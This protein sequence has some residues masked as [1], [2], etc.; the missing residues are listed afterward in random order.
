MK[1]IEFLEI[2]QCPSLFIVIVL[3]RYTW[4]VGRR[5]F[6]LYS[7]VLSNSGFVFHLFLFDCLFLLIDQNS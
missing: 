2:T 1:G 6:N 3:S 5:N 7:Q 4:A